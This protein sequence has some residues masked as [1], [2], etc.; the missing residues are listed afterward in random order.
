MTSVFALQARTLGWCYTLPPFDWAAE[1][2]SAE[3]VQLP[4]KR[5]P[6]AVANRF[7]HPNPTPQSGCR[8]S[9]F[10]SFLFFRTH[11]LFFRPFP[12]RIPAFHLTNPVFLTPYSIGGSLHEAKISAPTTYPKKIPLPPQ[13]LPTIYRG[14]YFRRSKLTVFLQLIV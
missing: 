5:P 14:K 1:F 3:A 7:C 4:G 10:L 6:A 12:R 11:F 8:N 13:L 2:C 9:V